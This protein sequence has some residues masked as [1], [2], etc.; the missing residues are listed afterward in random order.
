ML[1]YWPVLLLLFYTF[2]VFSLK[3]IRQLMYFSNFNIVAV[4]SILC[5]AGMPPFNIFFLKFLVFY[6]IFILGIFP[7]I[8]P[9]LFISL[10]SLFY[11]IRIRIYLFNNI[12]VKKSVLFG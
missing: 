2:R 1:N 4:M 6:N 8:L 7:L 12:F 10:G 3:Y 5:L 9:I 11:Y